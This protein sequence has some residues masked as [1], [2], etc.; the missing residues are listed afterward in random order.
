MLK[1]HCHQKF[2]YYSNIGS[3]QKLLDKV[4]NIKSFHLQT[5]IKILIMTV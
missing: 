5:K 2:N 3:D 1:L 4:V